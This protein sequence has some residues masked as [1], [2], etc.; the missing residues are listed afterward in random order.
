MPARL[1]INAKYG[2]KWNT[3]VYQELEA[4]FIIKQTKEFV[5]SAE[6]VY[7]DIIGW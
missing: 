7:D 1:E 2:D 3:R 6:S 4:E 5:E